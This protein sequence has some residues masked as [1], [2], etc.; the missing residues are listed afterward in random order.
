MSLELI[1]AT[2]KYN[3]AVLFLNTVYPSRYSAFPSTIKYR[4]FDSN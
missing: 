3:Y 2:E 1:S 4:G